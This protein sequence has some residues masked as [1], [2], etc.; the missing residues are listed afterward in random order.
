MAGL[1]IQT[2]AQGR[3]YIDEP[4]KPRY[5]YSPMSFGGEAPKDTT[6]LLRSRPQ[7]DTKQGKWVT[8]VD[9]GN[10]AN[11]GVG[12]FLTA[13]M[14]NAAMSGAAMPTSI[15]AEAGGTSMGGVL[16]GGITAGTGAYGLP[17]SIAAEFGGTAMGGVLPGGVQ[18]AGAGGGMGWGSWFS[19]NGMDL[20]RGAGN[21]FSGHQATAAQSNAA[22]AQLAESKRQF[23]LQ[24]AF[25]ADQAAK[26]EAARLEQVAY[27]KQK[28]AEAKVAWE[29]DQAR[30]APYRAASAAILG[31]TMNMAVPAYQPA[32]G[33]P[34]AG[35]VP[36][37]SMAPQPFLDPQAPRYVGQQ[38]IQP[39]SLGSFLQ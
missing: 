12:T 15:S 17:T 1:N 32:A 5:Y 26:A 28:D 20:A 24:Q 39:G 7:W 16:P 18:G 22:A 27:L 8:P 34:P 6:G 25:L 11:I 23:D 19:K 33:G 21:L 3:K 10:L 38:T 35:Y 37:Q 36:G 2:D 13:G 30:R 29:A 4:G 14:A 9:W 31:R